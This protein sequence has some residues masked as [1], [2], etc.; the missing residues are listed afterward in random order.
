MSGVKIDEVIK[1]Y[2]IFKENDINRN[3]GLDIEEFERIFQ[4]N[5]KKN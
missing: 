3:G 2:E 5:K 4:E 1:F